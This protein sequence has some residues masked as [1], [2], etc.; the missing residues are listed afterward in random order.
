MNRIRG[1]EPAALP[2]PAVTKAQRSAAKVAGILYLLLMATGIWAEFFARGPLI[3]AG[4]AVETAR[5]IE[6]AETLFRAGLVANLMTFAAS[7]PLLV[8]LYVIVEPVSRGLALLAAGWRLVETAVLAVIALNDLAVLRL[9]G[10]AGYLQPVAREQLE[11]LARSLLALH[12][13][14]YRVGAFFLGLGSAVFAYLLFRSRY[15][16]P[17]LA[18]WGVF[19]SALLA[20]VSVGIM[21]VPHIGPAV[22]P[23]YYAPMFIFEV[24]LG[25]WL[26]TK[27]LQPPEADHG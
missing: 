27:G 24:G 4:D 6:A 26:L 21:I 22:I 1:E 7:V 23:A 25:V 5:N 14:G 20:S 11:A 3:V 10:G 13:D 18:A 17:I 12:S 8:A 9:L 2:A 19:A 15:V 16:H